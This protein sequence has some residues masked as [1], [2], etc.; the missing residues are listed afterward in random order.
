MK[1]ERY[2]ITAT[3]LLMAIISACQRSKSENGNLTISQPSPILSSTI[4]GH[5]K[6]KREKFTLL[7]G[8]LI[9]VI[10][11]MLIRETPLKKSH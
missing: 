4:S 8:K 10:S 11:L 7:L 2:L 5:L 6:L 3:L 9:F 1:V